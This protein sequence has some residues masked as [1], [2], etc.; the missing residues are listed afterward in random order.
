MTMRALKILLAEHVA[1]VCGALVAL[2]E[3][4]PDFKVVA[5]VR[6][7]DEIVS[8]AQEHQPDIAV[9]DIDLPGLDGLS[10]VA[11][12]HDKLPACRTLILTNLSRAGPPRRGPGG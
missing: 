7:G 12:L 6:N 1:M 9:V 8:A 2:I 11:Q 4:E 3:L 5:A 10:A